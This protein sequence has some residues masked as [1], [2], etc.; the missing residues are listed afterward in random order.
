VVLGRRRNADVIVVRAHRH[1]LA[2]E[3][4]VA[5]GEE[6][7]DVPCGRRRGRVGEGDRAAR[8]PGARWD[9][10]HED[11]RGEWMGRKT[12]SGST[13]V[14]RRGFLAERPTGATW[15]VSAT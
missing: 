3:R 9:T 15:Q 2:A 12:T 8:R 10:G 7:H 5:P 6:G 13:A 1:H 14:R 4:G 11:L